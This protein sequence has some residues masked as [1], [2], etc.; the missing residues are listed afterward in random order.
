MWLAPDE[1]HLTLFT[2]SKKTWDGFRLYF[3]LVSIA[4]VSWVEHSNRVESG[5]VSAD[6]TYVF[7]LWI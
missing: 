7:S 2:G 3:G 4:T 1:G 6:V 5:V